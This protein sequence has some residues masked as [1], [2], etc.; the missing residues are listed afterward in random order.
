M[1]L[2]V[3]HSIDLIVLHGVLVLV[4]L[5]AAVDVLVSVPFVAEI[6]GH[7]PLAVVHIQVVVASVVFVIHFPQSFV[8]LLR[9]DY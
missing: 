6:G 4:V 7:F 8:S 5:V 9:E 2:L 3:L 1:L